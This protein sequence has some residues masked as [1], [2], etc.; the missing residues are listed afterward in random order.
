MRGSL[1]AFVLV[2][3]GCACQPEDLRI[4]GNDR[5]GGAGDGGE[6]AVID[7]RAEGSEDGHFML[8]ADAQGMC[9]GVLSPDPMPCNKVLLVCT[10]PDANGIRTPVQMMA[11]FRCGPASPTKWEACAEQPEYAYFYNC[12]P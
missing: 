6:P 12:E 3:G 7:T 11:D 5:D 8:G 9:A 4:L 2:L 10:P 1:L